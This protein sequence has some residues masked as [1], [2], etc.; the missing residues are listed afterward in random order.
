M[1]LIRE[2]TNIISVCENSQNYYIVKTDNPSK[3]EI[4]DT[5]EKEECDTYSWTRV[6]AAV[7]TGPGWSLPPT[8]FQIYP[9]L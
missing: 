5:E 2:L 1:F 7:K 4:L 9:E 3:T 6:A 8:I